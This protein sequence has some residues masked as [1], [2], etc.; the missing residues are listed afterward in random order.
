LLVRIQG[1]TKNFGWGSRNL[2]QDH[3]SFGPEG[4]VIAEVWFGT[5]PAGESTLDGASEKLSSLIGKRLTFLVKFL[6]ASSPLSIQVHPNL[7][8]ARDGF[9]AETLAGLSLDDPARNFKDQFHKPEILIALTPFRALCGIRPRSE[10]QEIFTALKAVDQ[11]FGQ[12]AEELATGKPLEQLGR[13]LIFDQALAKKLSESTEALSQD[14]SDSKAVLSAKKL[15]LELM[16]N[17]PGDT[18]VLLALMLNLV[19]LTPGQAIFLPAGNLH[20]YLEGLGIEV[21][22]ASDNVIRGGLSVKHVDK[23]TLLTVADF[24]ELSN[25]LVSPRKLA[26]GLLEYPILA[27]EFR[28][29]RADLSANNLLADIELPAEAMVICVSGEVAVGTSLEEREVLKRSEV[30]YLAGAKKFSLSGSGT[31]FVVLGQS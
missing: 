13:D 3:L 8:Q 27:E 16:A 7:I 22:A 31:V 20:A 26:E 28:V 2:I 9:E 1:V 21:M 19:E 12:L 24:G 10:I 4:E 17:Y 23:E 5:H 15:L 25:P 14:S 11:R 18:G 30:V 6:A 29:Y